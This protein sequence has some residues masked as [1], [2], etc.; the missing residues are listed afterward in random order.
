M[1]QK[2]KL[3]LAEKKKV[4]MTDKKKLC[5]EY[6][7]LVALN[8]SPDYRILLPNEIPVH[9]D[10]FNSDFA[11]TEEFIEEV[12]RRVPG[13]VAMDISEIE[14]ILGIDL[15]LQATET[16]IRYRDLWLGKRMEMEMKY[17][18]AFYYNVKPE[19]RV[20]VETSGGMYICLEK[21][22]GNRKE[23]PSRQE[24]HPM[25]PE[26]LRQY[27]LNDRLFHWDT[28]NCVIKVV[29]MYFRNFAIMF[30]NLG[31]E[32]AGRGKE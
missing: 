30:N 28:H 25:K 7:E 27:S 17:E 19:G 31:L 23:L 18:W 20:F 13:S 5:L 10:V 21:N 12:I 6:A 2:E 16:G 11:Y 4:K 3:F 24:D 26:K 15:E 22:Y 29:N 14:R 9:P 1:I 8:R 32:R